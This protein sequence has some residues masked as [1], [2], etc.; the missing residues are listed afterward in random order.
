MKQPWTTGPLGDIMLVEPERWLF[1]AGDWDAVEAEL[2]T[3]LPTD[4]KDL[5]GDGLACTFDEEL[6]IASPFDPHPGLNL[7]RT[8]ARSA[9]ALAYLRHQDADAYPVAVHPE[10]GG[11]LGWGYDGGGGQYHWDTAA[12]DP[13]RWAIAV[14]GR[15]VF[16]PYVQRHAVGLSEYLQ[17]LAAGEI[18]AAALGGW[19]SPNAVIE[20][21]RP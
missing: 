4:Y 5:I 1:N 12:G 14:T 18:K 6:V 11:L 16:D 20:R 17:R 21:R 13:Q 15:P 19:P 3:G 10:A 8:V 2:G 7:M 9:W